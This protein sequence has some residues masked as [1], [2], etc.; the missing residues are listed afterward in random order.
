MK[1]KILAIADVESKYYW[2]FFEK[3]K[4]EGIDLI[5]S[6]GDLAPQYLSF[7]ATYAKVP[8]LYVHG[9]HDGCYD[10]TPPDGCECIDDRIYV[11]RGVRILG[12][13][14]SMCYNFSGYQF[15]ESQMRRR[16]RK[17][18]LKLKLKKGFDILVAHS[19]ALGINDG[20]DL[21]HRGFACFTS[22]IIKKSPKLF[23]HGHVHMNYG[24]R[25]KRE[26]TFM[27]TRV[28]NAFERYVFEEEFPD[29]KEK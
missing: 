15:T 22:L 4:L 28:I 25:F 5:I 29:A 16:V 1:L 21:P 27:N 20:E 23:L 8:V 6:C 3:S 11:Y 12:L 17:L 13:G 18:F 24:R 9:N 7:L 14:G 2:D 26:D 19:P 10:D